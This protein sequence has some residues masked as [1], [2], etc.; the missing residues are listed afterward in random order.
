MRGAKHVR[1]S[2]TICIWL[3][4]T[5]FAGSNVSAC[6]YSDNPAELGSDFSV[7]VSDR[8]KPVEELIIELST[9][10]GKGNRKSRTVLILTTDANLD[11]SPWDGQP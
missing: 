6:E 7:S 9:N 1:I 4:L 8:G 5:I 11:K 10:P 3:S 2:I